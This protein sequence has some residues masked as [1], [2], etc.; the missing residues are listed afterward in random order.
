MSGVDAL[1][2]SAKRNP[3]KEVYIP[4][5]EVPRGGL[6]LLSSEITKFQ[7]PLQLGFRNL[8]GF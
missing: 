6:I 1:L 4:E 5:E 2:E 8:S 3:H 7:K